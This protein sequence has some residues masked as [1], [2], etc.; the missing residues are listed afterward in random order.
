MPGTRFYAATAARDA[1]SVASAMGATCSGTRK[2]GRGVWA[3]IYKG[4]KM[5]LS[6]NSDNMANEIGVC[7]SMFTPNLKNWKGEK[8]CRNI[9]IPGELIIVNF[10]FPKIPNVFIS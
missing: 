8:L 7:N 4:F 10:H 6:G 9:K 5:A 2:F 1:L 3:T